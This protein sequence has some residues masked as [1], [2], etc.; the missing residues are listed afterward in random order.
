MPR[1]AEHSMPQYI[2]INREWKYEQ[3]RKKGLICS[4]KNKFKFLKLYAPCTN[5]F[6]TLWCKMRHY[7]NLRNKSRAN[8]NIPLSIKLQIQVY[9]INSANRTIWCHASPSIRCPN[10]FTLFAV[11][12]PEECKCKAVKHT[13][14]ATIVGI[15]HLLNS[16]RMK[17]TID[18]SILINAANKF[19]KGRVR[20]R[21]TKQR[22]K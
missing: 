4:W 21:T 13:S 1:L 17:N 6:A 18:K 14:K 2:H 5:I 8:S 9:A 15:Y 7:L 22:L 12:A 19:S 10:T 20:S 16:K 11:A 3:S